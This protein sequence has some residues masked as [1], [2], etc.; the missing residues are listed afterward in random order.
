LAVFFALAHEVR[1]LS[2]VA[3][4]R[5]MRAMSLAVDETNLQALLNRESAHRFAGYYRLAKIGGSAPE[6]RALMQKTHADLSDEEKILSGRLQRVAVLRR[7]YE[8]AARR[9]WASVAP[10]PPEPR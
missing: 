2:R 10:D 5:R 3:E 7:K 9:P 8:Q 1:R 4:E 6:F